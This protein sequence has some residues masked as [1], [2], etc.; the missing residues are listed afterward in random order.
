MAEDVKKSRKINDVFSDYKTNSNIADAEIEKMNLKKKEN[1][2]EIEMSSK[3]Y[4]EIKEIWYF[5]KFL[6]QRFQF[7]QV[8]MIIKYPEGI[9]IKSIKDEW[10][11]L[12]CYMAHKYPLMRPLLLLKSQVEVENQNINVYMKI[13]GAEFLKARKLDRELENV[14]LNLFGKKYIVKE[15]NKN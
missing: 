8:H 1:A 7:G 6:R 12:I 9:Y 15:G 10:E 11:N 14:I 2:L 5:E 4:I 13:K 3:E